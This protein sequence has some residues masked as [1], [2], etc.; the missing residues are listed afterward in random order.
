MRHRGARKHNCRVSAELGV[1][2]SWLSSTPSEGDAALG[3][4]WRGVQLLAAGGRVA[5]SLRPPLRSFLVLVLQGL[6]RKFMAG[7]LVRAEAVQAVH[8]F[9][10]GLCGEGTERAQR[11]TRRLEV[12]ADKLLL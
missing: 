1:R 6:Y 8:D 11:Y 4:F 5:E 10:F 3:V 7:L 12:R 9:G 2:L